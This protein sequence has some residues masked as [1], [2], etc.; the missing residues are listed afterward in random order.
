VKVGQTVGGSI[1]ITEG[2]NGGELVAIT[3]LQ[4]L[5]PGLPVLAVP[6]E[7]PIGG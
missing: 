1:I 4:G 5:R 2:L 7:K 6:A 3:G